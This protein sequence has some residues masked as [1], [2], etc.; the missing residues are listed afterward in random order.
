[1]NDT[2]EKLNAIYVGNNYYK[3]DKIAYLVTP[4]ID[5]RHVYVVN[6]DS[7][8][9]AAWWAVCTAH[10][11]LNVALNCPLPISTELCTYFP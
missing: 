4:F 3:P 5:D 8:S 10:A 11:F 1:M 9:A 2:K 7:H 6:K